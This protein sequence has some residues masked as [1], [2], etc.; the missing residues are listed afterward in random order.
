MMTIEQFEE[1]KARLLALY[2]GTARDAS[3]NRARAFALLYAQS[4]W[5][6]Q[7][8]AEV[9]HM[10][11]RYISCLIIFGRFLLRTSS[12]KML[13]MY[14]TQFRALWNRTDKIASEAARFAAIDE[15]LQESTTDKP[16]MKGVGK[17]LIA[18]FRDGKYHRLRD[19]AEA[20]DAD[21]AVVRGLCDRIVSQGTFRTFGERRPAP[22]AQGSYAYRFVKGGKKKIDLTA[23]YAEVKPV[24][25]EMES[26]INGH[27]V[28][29]SQQAMKMMFARF[30]QVIERVA[31]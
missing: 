9:E 29:F 3:G 5:T 14:E 18:Q 21:M 30:R 10:T 25:D 22:T 28:D 1:E 11:Q 12:S 8:L 15:L 16:A 27:S 26:V 2:G 19:M 23:F 4:G 24:L 17:Q 6:Q 31:R 13:P 20:L 7:A